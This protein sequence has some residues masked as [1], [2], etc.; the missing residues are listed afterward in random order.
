MTKTV[1]EVASISKQSKLDL[2]IYVMIKQVPIPKAMKTT[3]DG[4]MDR[5]GKSQMNPHCTNALEEALALKDKVGGK[6]TVVSMGPPNAQQSLNEALR[7]GADR[8][9]LLSDR[10]LAGSDTWAT[11]EALSKLINYVEEKID[12][13]LNLDI[14]FA[15]LQTI[16][17]DTA[18][19]G[20]QVAG[21]LGLYQVTYVEDIIPVEGNYLEIRRI[22]EGGYQRLK[23]P[24]PMML[25]V[26]HT[27]NVPRGPSLN[28]SMAALD[29]EIIMVD[30]ATIGLPDEHAGLPGSPT[31]VSRVKNVKIK[32]AG[33]VFYDIG[34]MEERIEKL[35]SDILSNKTE[36]E[37]EN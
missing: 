17:G 21:R 12:G 28:A 1:S 13:G 36:P 14:I 27:A 18:H 9:Y 3:A 25:S 7:K 34:S 20:P 23:V 24:Y 6:I 30:I 5:S 19:V 31:V 2:N 37:E 10:K 29:K 15:G 26:T 22:V 4:L 32:H 8:A 33:T 16:D 11:A 35:T